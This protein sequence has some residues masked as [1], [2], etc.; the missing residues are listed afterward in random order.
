MRGKTLEE[1]FGSTPKN[2]TYK[3]KTTQNEIIDICGDLLTKR[4]T[5]EV[6]KA[7]YFSI[8]AD[9]AAD[10]GNVEQLSLVIRFVDETHCIREQF[11]GFIP[12]KRGLSGD[13]IATTIKEF[14]REQNLEIDDCRGQGCDGAGNMAGR[15]SGAAARIQENYKKALYVHCNSHILN[16]CVA[17]CCKEQLV[18]NMMGHVRV[19][20]EFFNFSP[21][22]FDLLVKTIE[23]IC[24]T[25]SHKRLINVCK[26]RWVARIDGLSV[27]IEV[28]PAI[29]KCL[30]TIRDDADDSWN[31]ESKR[32]A[33]FLHIGTISF[34]FIA[35]LVVVSRCLEV[36]RPLT[37]Q[38]Q[39]SA[40][41]A[42]AAREK[43]SRLYVHLEKLR[44]EVDVRHELWY[45]EAVAIAESVQTKPHRPRI[46]GRQFHRANTPADSPPEYY[47]RVVTIPFLDHLRSQI[48]TRFSETNLDVMNA[49]YGL[50]KNVITCPNWKKKF[51]KFLD[52][53]Q[54]DLPQPRFLD[55]E[56]EMWSERCRM[57]KGPLPSKLTDVLPFV[58]R[59]SFP[60]IYT[61]LQIFATIPVTTCTCERSISVLRR[62]KTYLRSTMSESRLTGLALLNVHREIQLDTEEIINECAMKHPRRMMLRL[63]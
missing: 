62:L 51:S 30:E 16:L 26:T 5:N 58:D 46:A 4:I 52:L 59:V 22:R 45:Q 40:I 55:T 36:T 42:G 15:L 25:S 19:T 34:P 18:S 24:P 32:R 57:E 56:L 48:Q 20:S 13:A 43:V 61:A 27:F 41:D 21:K 11:L 7:K 63:V 35:T 14:L 17:T 47:K 31:V 53:Y 6:R 37:V 60:N 12:S 44:N 2:I 28:F 23:E 10:C 49:V 50:P 1:F 3:S 9:E 33:C 29:V 8:L 38:L 39:E 54:D